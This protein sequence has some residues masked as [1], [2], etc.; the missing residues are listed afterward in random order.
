MCVEVRCLTSVN[1]AGDI[2]ACGDNDDSKEVIMAPIT[3]SDIY[4]DMMGATS[5]DTT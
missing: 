2:L 5:V 3:D 1:G 4:G